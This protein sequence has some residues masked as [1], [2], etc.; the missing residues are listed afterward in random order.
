M[1]NGVSSGSTTPRP[2][3]TGVR[4]QIFNLIDTSGDGSVD[5]NE[6]VALL[7]ENTSPLV[8]GLFG[9]VDTDQNDLI[10]QIEVDSGL[11]KL[12]QQMKQDSGMS[13]ASGTQ[14]PQPPENRIDATD[15]NKEDKTFRQQIKEM[16][17]GGATSAFSGIQPPPFLEKAFDTADVNQD[18]I[19]TKEELAAVTGQ[20]G[21]NI[22][23]LFA[24]IDTDGDGAISRTESESFPQR[25]T[26]P[27]KGTADSGVTGSSSS[28]T[29]QTEILDSL[30]KSFTS[31]AASS[32]KSTSLYA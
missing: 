1:I 24:K 4:Q 2:E 3:L 13:A 31:V 29:W 30:L 6:L 19:V 14:P 25:G 18:G 22:G 5:K 16:Q 20:R 15:V 12:G 21:G 10:S 28:R 23:Q 26:G 8:E 27:A 11:A 7:G 17:Q 9:I 32:G